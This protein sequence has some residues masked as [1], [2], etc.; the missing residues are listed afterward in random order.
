MSLESSMSLNI[1]SSLLVKAAPHSEE[2]FLGPRFGHFCHVVVCFCMFG[3]T[4]MDWAHRVSALTTLIFQHLRRHFSQPTTFWPNLFC[5][6]PQRRLF[7]QLQ[8]IVTRQEAIKMKGEKRNRR[9]THTIDKSKDYHDLIQHLLQFF[10]GCFFISCPQLW[11]DMFCWKEEQ[12]CIFYK[13]KMV[14]R[15]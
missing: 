2:T 5:K 3:V 14:K 8:H 1:P 12:N 9:G 15:I 10:I 13:L 6:K 4:Q 11:I 7:L